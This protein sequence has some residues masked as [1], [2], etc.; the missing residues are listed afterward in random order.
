M[1]HVADAGSASN[2]KRIKSWFRSSLDEGLAR[3]VEE[4][5]LDEKQVAEVKCRFFLSL[6]G[7]HEAGLI[8][9]AIQYH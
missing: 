9:N 4:S 2:A 1:D 6:I 3:F 7:I 8:P 5:G